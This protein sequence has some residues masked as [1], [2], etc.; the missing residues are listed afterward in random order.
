MKAGETGVGSTGV[1]FCWRLGGV[2]A[3]CS[4]GA[5]C[6]GLH[7]LSCCAFSVATMGAASSGLGWAGLGV[8]SFTVAGKVEG[9]GESKRGR[10]FCIFLYTYKTERVN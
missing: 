6:R 3:H 10:E 5:S 4:V 8:Q 2:L 1:G 7:V 9:R